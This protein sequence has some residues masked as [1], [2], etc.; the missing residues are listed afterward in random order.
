MFAS[1]MWFL[2]GCVVMVVLAAGI[3]FFGCGKHRRRLLDLLV[4]CTT[5]LANTDVTFVTSMTMRDQPV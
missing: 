5:R 2:L 1:L 4:Y 3:M